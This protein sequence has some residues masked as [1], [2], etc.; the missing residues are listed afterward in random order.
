MQTDRVHADLGLGML[1]PPAIQGLDHDIIAK[2]RV[3]IPKYVD[4]HPI[5]PGAVGL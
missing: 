1:C 5:S 3:V 2:A 4:R